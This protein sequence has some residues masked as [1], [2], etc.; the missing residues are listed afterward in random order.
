MVFVA[1]TFMLSDFL[2]H[3]YKKHLGSVKRC[4]VIN[5]PGNPKALK[6]V[7]SVLEDVV[8]HAVNVL[9][10]QVRATHGTETYEQK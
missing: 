2:L 6:E 10:D 4:L 5:L 1:K 7:F 3:L 9:K 8:P